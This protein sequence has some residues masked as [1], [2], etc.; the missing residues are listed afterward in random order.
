MQK[1]H[2]GCFY[3]NDNAANDDLCQSVMASYINQLK[4]EAQRKQ[5]IREGRIPAPDC[6]WGSFNISDRHWF[7]L[8]HTRLIHM[9]RLASSLITKR[10]QFVHD[11]VNIALPAYVQAACERKSAKGYEGFVNPDRN[12]YS[13]E[14]NAK[15]IVSPEIKWTKWINLSNL[16]LKMISKNSR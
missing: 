7:T 11:R 4:A 3:V 5:D 15:R 8:T 16:L 1:V 13:H 10:T 9:Y 2:N 6:S 14:P 12:R